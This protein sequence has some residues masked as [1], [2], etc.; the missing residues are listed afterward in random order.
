MLILLRRPA[1]AEL[2]GEPV[3]TPCGH[4]FCAEC[5]RHALLCQPR[6]PLC[7]EQLQGPFRVNH[8]LEDMISLLRIEAERPP[9]AQVPPLAMSS[10]LSNPP[11]WAQ[12]QQMS[13]RLTPRGLQPLPNVSPRLPL[14]P[15]GS[16]QQQPPPPHAWSSS[17]P[18]PPPP[19]PLPAPPPPQTLMPIQYTRRVPTEVATLE[20]AAREALP[21]TI[22][23]LARGTHHLVTTLCL[24][25]QIRIKGEGSASEVQIVCAGQCGMLVER[26]GYVLVSSVTIHHTRANSGLELGTQPSQHGTACAVRVS[27][28]SSRLLL[29]HC[30][31]L[32]DGVG[33]AATDDGRLD[34]QHTRVHD[35][36]AH[37]VCV[38]S[39]AKGCIE[40]CCLENNVGSGIH[41][42]GGTLEA[43][44]NTVCHNQGAGVQLLGRCCG[45]IKYN[46]MYE[47]RRKNVALSKVPWWARGAIKVLSNTS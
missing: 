2:L 35:C 1:P 3:S 45:S 20:Q 32:A 38:L 7:R 37:G 10:K 41:A 6:C 15:R 43:R 47:N 17:Q 31:V 30:E 40:D 22:I 33:V 14:R 34:L 13:G 46:K 36:K 42:D 8:V 39:N 26:G 24:S 29:D 5:L 12:E 21:G 19:A 44:R 9:S 11:A 16:S 23:L 18:H 27:G 28:T 4:N 25:K